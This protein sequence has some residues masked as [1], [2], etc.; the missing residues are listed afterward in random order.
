MTITKIFKKAQTTT[1]ETNKTED[2]NTKQTFFYISDTTRL[3]LPQYC[4]E[5]ISLSS[6]N[7]NKRITISQITNQED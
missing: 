5:Y 1:I 2:D 4:V 6:C 7:N 3:Y